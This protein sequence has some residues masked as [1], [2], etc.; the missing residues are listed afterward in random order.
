MKT[1]PTTAE[2]Q[3]GVRFRL[4]N[5]DHSR[6]ALACGYVQEQ[7]NG[8]HYKKLFMEHSHFHVMAG[9]HGDRFTTW[10][11]Y[12]ADQLTQARKQFRTIK[13]PKA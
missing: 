9:K 7:T 10:D 5:G 11:T 8:P 12:D 6:Y 1:A 3:I 2:N 13:L 4:K